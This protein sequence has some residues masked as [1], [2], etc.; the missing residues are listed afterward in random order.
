M[1]SAYLRRVLGVWGV[2]VAVLLVILMTAMADPFEPESF[3]PGH[4]ARAYWAAPL[5]A[6]Y[7]PGSVGQES[8]YLYSPAFLLAVSLGQVS[9][10]YYV[11]LILLALWVAGRPRRL[12]LLTAALAASVL[13]GLAGMPTDV[14]YFWLSVLFVALPTALWVLR[15]RERAEIP[16]D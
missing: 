13:V 1:K 3:G 14:Q 4:D 8:A 5:H 16:T 12:G 9:S 2:L 15:F 11:F 7:E 10:Y 6:P